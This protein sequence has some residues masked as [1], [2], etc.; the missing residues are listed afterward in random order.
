[1][2]YRVQFQPNNLLHAVSLLLFTAQRQVLILL[3]HMSHH[4]SLPIRRVCLVSLVNLQ[5]LS[6][7]QLFRQPM[8]TFHLPIQV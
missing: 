4:F 2:H 3:Y 1:M 7:Q 8:L 5:A 6:P